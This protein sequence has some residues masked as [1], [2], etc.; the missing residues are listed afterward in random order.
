MFIRIQRKKGLITLVTY[1]VLFM[2]ITFTNAFAGSYEIEELSSVAVGAPQ[3]A[4]GDAVEPTVLVTSG[5]EGEKSVLQ[6]VEIRLYGVTEYA[7]VEIFNQ[8]VQ[9]NPHLLHV[10]REKTTITPGNPD[11]CVAIWTADTREVDTF[12]IE[13][14]IT[15]AIDKLSVENSGTLAVP[16]PVGEENI[17]MMK[18]IRPYS[19]TAKTLNFVLSRI[20]EKNIVP[21]LAFGGIHSSQLTQGFD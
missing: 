20:P 6:H 21:D 4:I 17:E 12:A 15:D 8:L 11:R 18:K 2:V 10:V 13:I 16:V 5:Q 19:A 1:S 3:P 7:Q 9:D 14:A